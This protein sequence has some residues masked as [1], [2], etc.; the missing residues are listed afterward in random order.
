[1]LVYIS[2]YY[3]GEELS[4]TNSSRAKLKNATFYIVPALNK[5]S[6]GGSLIFTPSAF[7]NA[8]FS[9]AALASSFAVVVFFCD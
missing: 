6:F 1:M 3:L 7:L 9:S 4:E 2:F 5:K 8:C